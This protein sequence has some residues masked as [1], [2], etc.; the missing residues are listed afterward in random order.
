MNV[1]LRILRY[2]PNLAPRLVQ[3][4]VFSTLAVLFS[5]SYLG[6]IMPMLEVLFDDK[7]QEVIPLLPEFSFGIDFIKGFFRHHFIRIIIEHGRMDALLFVCIA[8]VSCVFLA[9][10]FRY[11]ER[12]AASRIKV[13][14]VRNMRM[15]IFSKV[16]NL[17]IGYFSNNRKGDLMSRFTNDISEVEISVVNSLKAVLKEPITIIVYL[18][19]LFMISIKLTLFTL[20]L[21]PI[22][23]GIVAEIIKRLK[24][25]AKQSQE[26]MG[27]I[28]NI[29]DETFS[30][31]RV[32]KA[33]NR[34]ML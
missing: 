23:G 2:T 18:V 7:S 12:M 19:V 10:V 1:Y 8:I 26:A 22:T 15:D 34:K 6:L 11:M 29:L 24:R 33:F 21:L 9:N 14:V 17:H 5:A 16:M 25:K 13:D 3:F 20:I 30:G 32:I 28:V 4:F 27:R 31:M